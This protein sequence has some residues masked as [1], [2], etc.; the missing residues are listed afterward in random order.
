MELLNAA[1][2]GTL[3]QFIIFIYCFM[4][5]LL[6]FMKE[7]FYMAFEIETQQNINYNRFIKAYIIFFIF[8]PIIIIAFTISNLYYMF[9]IV[10]FGYEP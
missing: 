5:L 3:S 7:Q 1:N 9:H 2:F 6:L 10:L 8:S 4:F